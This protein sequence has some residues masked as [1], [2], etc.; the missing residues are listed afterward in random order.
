MLTVGDTINN[1]YEWVLSTEPPFPSVADVIYRAFFA[2]LVPGLLL[3]V[4]ART[5]AATAPA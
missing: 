4:R 2:L 3:L 1:G 5:P